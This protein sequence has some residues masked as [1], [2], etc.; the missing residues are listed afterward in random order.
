MDNAIEDHQFHDDELKITPEEEE[1][2]VY[3]EY[4]ITTYPSDFTLS[5]IYKMWQDQDILVPDFQRNYVWNIKQASLLVESFLLGLPVPPVFFYIDDETQQSLVVDGQQR[6]RSIVYFFEGYWGEENS[7]GRKKV[8][9]LVGLDKK[10]PYHKKTFTDLSMSAQRKLSNSV[11][12]ALNIR[13]LTPKEDNTSIYHIFE[14]LN[15]G[16][17]P[18]RPQEIRNCV[19]RGN[20]IMELHDLNE[21]NS[22]KK[23]LGKESPDKHQ[24]DIEILLRIFALSKYNGI[25]YEKPMKEFLN[26]TMYTHK[27]ANKAGWKNFKEVFP[28]ICKLIIEQLGEKPFHVRGP[29]N[30]SVMDSVMGTLLSHPNKIRA[31]LKEGFESLIFDD[32]YIEATQK[33]TSDG[34]VVA[35]R[36]EMTKKVLLK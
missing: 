29:L 9:R 7:Q 35:V 12:R 8:F 1:D 33:S 6:I 24:K 2:E 4:D 13:Q 5:N 36:F 32:R 26:K 22:W 27:D 28:E 30:V 17:T 21:L 18:L 11:L 16:G 20:L 10:S 19:F 23:I 15:T 3:I 25:E 31:A 34:S 14:R